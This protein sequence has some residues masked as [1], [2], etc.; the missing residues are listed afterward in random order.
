MKTKF[1][2]F[3][4]KDYKPYLLNS[5]EN[6]SLTQ[7]GQKL[8]LAE[9]LNC[10]PSYI[11]SI[12]NGPAD[13]SLEQAQAANEFLGHTATESKYFLTLVLLAR[14]GTPA[15]RKVYGEEVKTLLE[16][17]L[18]VK[19]RVQSNRALTEKEQ[20]QYYSSWYYA[21]IH[22]IVSMS[23][24]RTREK[25]AR[26][27][28]LPQKTVNDA[29]EFL[30]EIGILKIDGKQLKQGETNLFLGTDSPFLVRHQLNWRV[31]AIHSLDLPREKDLHYSGVIT[32]SKDDIQKIRE[33]MLETIKDI[34]NTVQASPKDEAMYV[35]NLD[36]FNLL[37]R[38]EQ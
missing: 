17:H 2:I 26:A 33:V 11:S 30:L 4:Y 15:L 14:A 28:N 34:R 3:D 27:L 20:A 13:L 12:L 35:Y 10:K 7:K 18:L 37:G 22:V 25:I 32:C 31:Q 24:F 19:N 38:E 1:S 5:L 8:R 36:L 6:R 23:D 16:Q 9:Y 21:G 29:V